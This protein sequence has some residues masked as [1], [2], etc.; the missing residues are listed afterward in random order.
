MPERLT[1]RGLAAAMAGAALS[2]DAPPA[3]QPETDT[4]AT[5]RQQVRKTAET[6]NAF[7]LPL[8][9]EP[10]FIFKPF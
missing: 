7:D 9:T 8:A 4:L 2:A 5:A 6:L 3:Q 10:A 1:R